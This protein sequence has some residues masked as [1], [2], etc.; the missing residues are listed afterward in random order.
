[1]PNSRQRG[2]ELAMEFSELQ[3]ARRLMV[4]VA[5]RLDTIK[6]LRVGSENVNGMGRLI[7]GWTSLC[8]MRLRDLDGLLNR[9][10]F[11]GQMQTM[12]DQSFTRQLSS[13]GGIGLARIQRSFHHAAHVS[14]AEKQN[15]LVVNDLLAA[16]QLS[17]T[18]GHDEP[19]LHGHSRL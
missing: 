17:Q 18:Q 19:P 8:D 4:E 2:L 11:G 1:M 3:R 6:H 7:A 10:G 15:L 5:K 9:I 14:P 13:I 12:T 16:K